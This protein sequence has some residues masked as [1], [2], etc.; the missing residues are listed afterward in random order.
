MLGDIT[1]DTNLSTDSKNYLTYLAYSV[2]DNGDGDKDDD[3]TSID[4][5][6]WRKQKICVITTSWSQ[7]KAQVVF[8][9]ILMNALY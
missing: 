8:N 1:T 3:D 5:S 7:S 4:D 9:G 6:T 2:Y